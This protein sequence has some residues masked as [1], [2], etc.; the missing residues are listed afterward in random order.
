MTKK[1]LTRRFGFV[2]NPHLPHWLQVVMAL[3]SMTL[4]QANNL[5][6][7]HQKAYHN[8]CATLKPPIGIDKL[9]WHGLKFVVEQPLPKPKLDNYVQRLT[10]DIR[11]RNF[12]QNLQLEEDSEYDPKL[13]LPSTDFDPDPA[14]AHT[15]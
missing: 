8:L 9:L 4:A 12:I 10:Y 6:R 1:N 2:S 7:Q 14:P 11:V 13:Y 15:V 3:Q 5:S